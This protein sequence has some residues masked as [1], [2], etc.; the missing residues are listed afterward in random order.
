[1]SKILPS[2]GPAVEVSEVKLRS[3]Y[4]GKQGNVLSGLYEYPNSVDIAWT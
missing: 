4:C 2:D 3:S 1:M